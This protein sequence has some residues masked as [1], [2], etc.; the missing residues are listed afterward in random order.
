[1]SSTG[2]WP[3]H[4]HRPAAPHEGPS[5]A[6]RPQPWDASGRPPTAGPS[7]TTPT[8]TGPFAT[9]PAVTGPGWPQPVQRR[10]TTLVVEIVGIALGLAGVVWMLS[11]ILSQGGTASTVVAGLLAF[12]PL[13]GVVAAVMWVDRWE[14]EPRMLLVTALAWGIGVSTAVSL[15]FN[16]LFA[17]SVLT[18]T[19]SAVH[20]SVLGTVIGAPLVEETAKGVGVLLIFLLRRRYFDGP[21]DGIVYAAVVAAGFAFTEN[22][23]YFVQFDDMLTEVFVSRAIQSPFAH[24]TF[25]ALIGIALGF[26][27]R[28]RSRYAWLWMFPVGW[29][30]ATMLHAVWNGSAV[31]ALYDVLYWVF[32]VPLFA[33]GIVLV[34]WLRNDEKATIG[35]RLTEYAR[36]GWFAPYEVEMLTSFQGRR[37]ARRWAAARGARAKD[38]MQDFQEAATSLAYTRQRALSGRYDVGT[39]RDEKELLAAVTR[40][41][42]G[43]TAPPARRA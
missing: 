16:E 11:L 23:L 26:A 40:A 28:A 3:P 6:G 9:T 5:S 14:P 7:A 34:V 22:I 21:V 1:M 30:A 42:D 36:A 24:V 13:V 10:T 39:R 20:A 27:S 17:L 29:L 43:F 35:N 31:L 12:V 2:P 32:Q 41:R 8:V 25:T 38:A 19:G 33:A 37:A 18:T 15:V 4:E